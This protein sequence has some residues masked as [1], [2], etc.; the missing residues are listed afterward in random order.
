MFRYRP[1]QSICGWSSLVQLCQPV[2]TSS[3]SSSSSRSRRLPAYRD[4]SQEWGH[5]GLTS[6][7]KKQTAPRTIST[8]PMSGREK[9]KKSTYLQ[10]PSSGPV[11][12]RKSLGKSRLCRDLLNGISR[13]PPDYPL[14]TS[15]LHLN[16]F[17]TFLGAFV[18][19]ICGA[20]MV[21]LFHE[22]KSEEE[23]DNNNFSRQ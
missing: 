4:S 19:M 3:S 11:L 10:M 13:L 1:Y 8:H 12:R 2:W 5:R 14:L 15:T 21:S 7:E 18:K 17:P 20:D 6:M 22:N 16:P 9:V 23:I